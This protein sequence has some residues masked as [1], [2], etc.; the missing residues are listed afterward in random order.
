[1]KR[2]P[3][4]VLL[5]AFMAACTPSVQSPGTA[6]QAGL[7]GTGKVGP[8]G[9]KIGNPYQINGVWYYPKEDFGYDETGIASWYGADFHNR[10]TSNGE[11]FDK[12]EL[13]AAHKTLPMPSLVRVTNLENG[14]SIVARVN[15][16]GPFTPGRVIDLS[17]RGAQLLGFEG[18][19][20]AKVRVQILADESR[21]LAEAAKKGQPATAVAAAGSAEPKVEAA[22]VTPVQVAKADPL[23]PP[24]ASNPTAQPVAATKPAEPEKVA[25]PGRIEENRFLPAAKVDNVPVK[26]ERAIWIQAGAFSIPEN[27]TRLK[28]KL[29]AIGATVISPVTVGEAQLHRVRVGPVA[30]VAKADEVLDRVISMGLNGARIV[31]E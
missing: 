23:P 8:G 19:G 29:A 20:T 28:E 4:A 14:R 1:M 3:A 7:A 11:T 22:P 9:Y 18:N 10:R 27:A 13:T 6:K 26:G 31:V 5:L 24:S 2:F 17:Q 12:N 15:D 16:R 25:L 21:T 30:D